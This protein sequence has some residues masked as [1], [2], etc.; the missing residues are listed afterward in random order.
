MKKNRSLCLST[1]VAPIRQFLSLKVLAFREVNNL[2]QKH[3][4]KKV[5][6][7]KLTDKFLIN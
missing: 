4:E 6:V 1:Y 7:L 5:I 3:I 2:K